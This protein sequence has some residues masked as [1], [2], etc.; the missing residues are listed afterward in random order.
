MNSFTRSAVI[1]LRTELEEA[2]QKVADKHNLIIGLGNAS[3]STTEATFNK[4]KLVP[5]VPTV[6]ST[7]SI[8]RPSIGSVQNGT[9]PY[10]TLESREY[11]N[12]GYLRG[13]PKEWLG[14]QFRAANGVYTLVG[15]NGSRPKFPLIGTSSRGTRYKFTVDAVKRGIIL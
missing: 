15:L 5:K 13:L 10:N 9:D 3:F 6:V 1:A 11:L 4:L 14:K 2:I 12:L 7:A 8:N